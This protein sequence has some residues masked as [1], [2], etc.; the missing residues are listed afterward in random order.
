MMVVLAYVVDLASP[1]QWALEVLML[2]Q[3]L[4]VH[5]Y[6]VIVLVEEPAAGEVVQLEGF[7]R[8]A[9]DASPSFVVCLGDQPHLLVGEN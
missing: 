6:V 1:Y 4:G 5:L 9:C 7:Q 2:V 3:G 8:G